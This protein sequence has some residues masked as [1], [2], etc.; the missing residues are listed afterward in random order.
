MRTSQQISTEVVTLKA[1]KP[2]V[3]ELSWFM[4]DSH[5]AA[6]DASVEVLQ[7]NLSNAFIA[8]RFGDNW[9]TF[10]HAVRAR[11]WLDEQIGIPPSATWKEKVA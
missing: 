11:E 9:H 4:G 5:W 2:L 10:K 1:L 6:I 7:R 3:P 8:H